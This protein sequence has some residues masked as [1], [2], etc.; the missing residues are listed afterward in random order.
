[1]TYYLTTN[2]GNFL[3]MQYG[4]SRYA[5]TIYYGLLLKEHLP[6]TQERLERD[7]LDH[8]CE[9]SLKLFNWPNIQVSLFLLTGGA[10]IV[11]IQGCGMFW[12]L[13]SQLDYLQTF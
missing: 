5:F 8:H 6:R 4:F 12:Y 1:M 10:G 13:T 7:C 3:E 11:N 9:R 2:R